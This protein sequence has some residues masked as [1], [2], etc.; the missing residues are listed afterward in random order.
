MRDLLYGIPIWEKPVLLVL[1]NCDSTSAI[2]RV[3][4]HYFKVK[5]RPIRRKCSIVRFY[6]SSGIANVNYIKSYDNIVDPLTKSLDKRKGF[7][8]HLLLK[9][10]QL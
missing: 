1:I 6:L 10:V 3:N 4:N 9:P 7:G 2:G 8:I 5:S